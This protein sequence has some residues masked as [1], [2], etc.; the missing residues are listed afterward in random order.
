[1]SCHFRHNLLAYLCMGLALS[2]VACTRPEDSAEAAARAFLDRYFV[3]LNQK[4]ALDLT[5]G[6][7]RAK[8]DDE[9]RRLAGHEPS[10]QEE[11]SRIY[12]RQ[13]SRDTQDDGV[14]FRFRL[15]VVIPGD[16]TV[17]PD[18]LVRVRTTDGHWRV[19]NFELLPLAL[20]VPGGG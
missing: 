4:A 14:A 6:V 13:V 19:S 9:I 18:V 5:E 15:T 10:A 11:R 17:E 12:Y 20:A 16:A 8:I 2:V 3:E 7:A 1:M